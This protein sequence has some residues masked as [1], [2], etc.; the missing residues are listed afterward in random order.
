MQRLANLRVY[1]RL[2][3]QS[4]RKSVSGMV[5]NL[6]QVVDPFTEDKSLVD[7]VRAIT[8]VTETEM[9]IDQAT[10]NEILDQIYELVERVVIVWLVAA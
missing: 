7:A 2:K 1:F 4:F 5:S 6:H 9:S 3:I 8:S 10:A